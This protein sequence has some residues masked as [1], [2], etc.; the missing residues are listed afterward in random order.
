MADQRCS[1]HR[2][3]TLQVGDSADIESFYRACRRVASCHWSGVRLGNTF[4]EIAISHR[5]TLELSARLSG[6]LFSMSRRQQ[7][8][9]RRFNARDLYFVAVTRRPTLFFRADVLDRFRDTCRKLESRGSIS[10]HVASSRSIWAGVTSSGITH[11]IRA[12]NLHDHHRLFQ[13]LSPLGAA[14]LSTQA[15]WTICLRQPMRA[16]VPPDP[17]RILDSIRLDGAAAV[18]AWRRSLKTSELSRSVGS[19]N[20]LLARSTSRQVLAMAAELELSLA[21]TFTAGIARD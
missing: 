15:Y 6:G 9:W 12:V 14:E 13:L 21:V 3:A 16:G 8:A 20:S 2:V 19:N 4:V 10:A 11:T 7:L 18:R 1:P 17:R 5:S